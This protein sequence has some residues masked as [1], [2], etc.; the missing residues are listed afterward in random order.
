M[1]LISIFMAVLA[2]VY[3]MS[4]DSACVSFRWSFDVKISLY[5]TLQQHITLR[6]PMILD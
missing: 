1:L 2:A 6:E 5:R 3:I 4:P